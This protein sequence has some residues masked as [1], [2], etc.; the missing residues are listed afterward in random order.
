MLR[1]VLTIALPSLTV[2]DTQRLSDG[3]LERAAAVFDA[4]RNPQ[5]LLANEVWRDQVRQALDRA[6]L[7]DL[8]GLPEE[9]RGVPG[10]APPS[11]VCRAVRPWRKARCAPLLTGAARVLLVPRCPQIR[12][13]SVMA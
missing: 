11:V 9:H 13:R 4:F 8:L 1:A 5:L 10:S 6:G 3:Q 7:M 12:I 2:L